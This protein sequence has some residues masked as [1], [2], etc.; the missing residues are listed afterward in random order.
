MNNNDANKIDALHRSGWE[1]SRREFLKYSLKYSAGTLGAISLS[2]LTFG[3]GGG[4]GGS[5]SPILSYPIDPDV[6]TTLD[7]MLSFPASFS[8]GLT[9]AQLRQVAQY[10]TYGY[11]N[12]TF[13][14]ALPLVQ[15]TVAPLG[16]MPAGY[17]N[18]TPVRKAKLLNF[19]AFTDIH[20]T[21]K[22]APNQ[23]TYLQ[24]I[25]QGQNNNTSIYSPVMMCTTQVLDAAMQTVNVLHQR[26]PFDFG[27][28]LGDTCNNTSYNELRWYI[29]VIDG[30]VITP[31]SGANLGADSIDYQKR[32]QAFGL[33]KSIPWYQALGNHDHFYIGS[34]PIDANPALGFRNSYLAD[35][36]WAIG[37]ALNPT[38]VFPYWFSMNNASVSPF[39]YMGVLDGTS[40]YGN[41]IYSGLA[42]V[43]A[44]PA[45]APKVAA[46]PNRRSLVRADWVQEFF[47]TTSSPV[48]HGFNLVNPT[49]AANNPG[50]A[51][52]SF[53][54][55]AKFPLKVIVLDDTRSENDGATDIH[56]QGYLDATRWTWLQNEL[57]Q[58]TAN[59]QLM[60]IAAHVPI[61]VA[62]IGAE[63]EWMEPTAAQIPVAANR[64]VI[65][66]ATLVATLQAT[67]NLLMWIAGHRHLNTVKAFPAAAGQPLCDGFWQ[68]ETGSLRDFPQQFRTFEIFLNSD[69]TVSI[70]TVNIDPS[71]AEGT[72]AATSRKYAIA[73]QQLVL[74]NVTLNN[75]NLATAFRLLPPP[76]LLPTMDPTRAQGGD[77]SS[78]GNGP[79][80]PSISFTDMT[81][82]PLPV[83]VNGSCNV[84]LFKTLSTSMQGV[85]AAMFP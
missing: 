62:A 73:A 48:G 42:T 20:I 68:V 3:C 15:R 43:A 2:S 7:R 39:Y 63:T 51:C 85:L 24:E 65:D 52:Y 28:S 34:F 9:A 27:I 4:G 23:I 11:G 57:T 78:P 21:D 18:P 66:L 22:E 50:F 31:S 76:S 46:D 37:N 47:N 30:Q 6:K 32:Y 17:S 19:F 41:V 79:T 10:A 38:E 80:D 72:P 29:D 36:V 84:E 69:Y 55:N 35:S 81:N 25:V 44:F 56:G 59:N 12:W 54:P 26:N 75:P 1:I 67:P 16:I 49:L 58:G 71:V 61:G 33:D 64:N 5:S 82:Y 53:V 83:P 60:I 8:P 40:P 14:S 74:N 45:G 77:F 13:G 70:V